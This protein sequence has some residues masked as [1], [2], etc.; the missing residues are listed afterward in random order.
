MFV[1][2]LFI[3]VLLYVL[4][5]WWDLYFVG[6]VFEDGIFRCMFWMGISV[7]NK[8]IREI[9]V[10]VIGFFMINVVNEC[11]LDWLFCL[12]IFKMCK[13]L[14]CV[15]NIVS[16]EGRSVRVENIV[17]KI[18]VIFLRVMFWKIF[19]WINSIF[20]NLINMYNFEKMIECFV[21]WMVIL[22]VCFIDFVWIF[23]LKWLINKRVKL[24]LRVNL[25]I[26]IIFKIKMDSFVYGWKK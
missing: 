26:G 10:I 5:V 18:I 8:M 25:I 14:I 11:Y 9:I 23:F 15:F 1:V 17:I 2:F 12:L 24:I 4:K 3:N 19:I 16:M 13:W 22:I 6:S 20:V 7:I 21:V